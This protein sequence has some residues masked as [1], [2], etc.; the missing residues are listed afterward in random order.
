MAALQAAKGLSGAPWSLCAGELT[1]R[2]SQGLVFAEIQTSTSDAFSGP[3]TA[4]LPPHQAPGVLR[5][6]L[7]CL[8]VSP[9]G[10]A[11]RAVS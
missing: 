8:A 10:Q 1:L 2:L 11:L 4:P 3:L 5:A 7:S 9:Q 6:C